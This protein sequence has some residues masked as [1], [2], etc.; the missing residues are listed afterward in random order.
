[1]NSGENTYLWQQQDWPHWR[2]DI[3]KLLN[4]LGQVHRAQ[5]NLLGFTRTMLMKR[6]SS[7]GA[8]FMLSLQR[9]LLRNYMLT[10]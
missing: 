1:M 7:N 6:L 5:G 10:I 8:V 4:L 2:Y 9:H 3:H